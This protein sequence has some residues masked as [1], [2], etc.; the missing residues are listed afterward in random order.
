MNKWIKI[1]KK[2]PE[3]GKNVLLHFQ[4]GQI[5]TG[6]IRQYEGGKKSTNRGMM[7]CKFEDILHWMELPEPPVD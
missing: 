2:L 3:N 1:S 6:A 4:S 5:E 7:S